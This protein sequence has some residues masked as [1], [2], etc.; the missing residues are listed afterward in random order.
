MFAHIHVPC[1]TH[2][3]T[4]A[5]NN[6]RCCFSSQVLA[7]YARH[8]ASDTKFA[9]PFSYAAYQAGIRYMGGKLD[10][11]TIL[12]AVASGRASEGFAEQSA[13]GISHFETNI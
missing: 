13:S 3:Q 6:K 5:N 4:P 12:V 2:R 9:S 7:H 8:R 11:I 10:D 1:P